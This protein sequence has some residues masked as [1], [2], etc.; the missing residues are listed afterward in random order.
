M[1]LKSAQ[2]MP[3]EPFNEVHSLAVYRDT[4]L[5]EEETRARWD[6][7]Y[8]QEYIDSFAS[9][10]KLREMTRTQLGLPPGEIAGVK[11]KPD[12]PDTYARPVRKLLTSDDLGLFEDD[13]DLKLFPPS[14]NSVRTFRLD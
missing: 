1:L 6:A 11:D 12:L 4:L 13:L 7:R 2:K 3:Q 14:A 10:A 5:A 9:G 8:G